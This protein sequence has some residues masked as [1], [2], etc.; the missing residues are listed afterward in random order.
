MNKDIFESINRKLTPDSN[1]LDELY[2]KADTLTPGDKY[3]DAPEEIFLSKGIIPETDD[4]DK[5]LPAARV[6]DNRLV[7]AAIAA[8]LA[9]A[10][11]ATAILG[12]VSQGK[13]ETTQKNEE[14]KTTTYPQGEIKNTE[15]D[16]PYP[17]IELRKLINDTHAEYRNVGYDSDKLLETESFKKLVSFS[18]RL[19][20][21]IA[22]MVQNGELDGELLSVARYADEVRKYND[23]NSCLL[24]AESGLDYISYY[25][26]KQG[27][28]DLNIEEYIGTDTFSE[29]NKDFAEPFI[30]IKDN[31]N[32]K[33]TEEYAQIKRFTA[34]EKYDYWST[35]TQ[36]Y[37][38]GGVDEACLDIALEAY[39]DAVRS[40]D[41]ETEF[42]PKIHVVS[43][44]RYDDYYRELAT[45]PKSYFYTDE[46]VEL[47]VRLK[48]ARVAYNSTYGSLMDIHEDKNYMSLQG[49]GYCTTARA[50]LHLI[51][52]GKI[53]Y[54]YEME[55]F[56][57]AVTEI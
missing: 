52:D 53:E 54:Y 46:E 43:N 38:L 23:S 37:Y 3:I 34:N 45:D 7:I 29:D 12:T 49:L 14:S 36:I 35:L 24:S 32:Y 40:G 18:D 27:I 55:G 2:K 31:D 17:W 42:F 33:D 26:R 51:E 15:T 16:S 1:V 50:I 21:Y 9:L 44:D 10:V 25:S 56:D 48:L 11:G 39:K 13:L 30:A 20:I 6:K 57:D 41:A 8:V 22:D 28:S 19:D 47:W 4:T 5:S